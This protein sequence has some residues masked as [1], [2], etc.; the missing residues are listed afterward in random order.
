M[1]DPDTA[2]PWKNSTKITIAA[3][4]ALL[5]VAAYYVGITGLF[6]ADP[7]QQFRPSD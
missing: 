1:T 5:A 2:A 6:A 4:I 7:A 3:L